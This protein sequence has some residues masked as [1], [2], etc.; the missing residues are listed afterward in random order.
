VSP[1]AANHP[2]FFNAFGGRDFASVNTLPVD[3]TDAPLR[4]PA[5]SIAARGGKGTRRPTAKHVSV[6][7]LPGNILD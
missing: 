2:L 3:E 7:D 6:S 1:M 4:L 5:P